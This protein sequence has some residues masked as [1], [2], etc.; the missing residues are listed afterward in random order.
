MTGELELDHGDFTH[1]SEMGGDLEADDEDETWSDEDPYD[2]WN[3]WNTIRTVC[4]Y[5]QKLSIG[6]H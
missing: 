2:S 5:S 6:M 1:L 4:N 3:T